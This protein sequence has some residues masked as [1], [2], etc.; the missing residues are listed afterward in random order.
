MAK[1]RPGSL[2]VKRKTSLT[3]TK[4]REILRDGK[5]H[6]KP[7]TPKQRRFFNAIAGG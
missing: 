6:G 1:K 4:A 5:V 2:Q 3:A 7:L